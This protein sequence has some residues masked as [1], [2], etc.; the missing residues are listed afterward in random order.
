MFF[1]LCAGYC[2]CRID[3]D[4]L[5]LWVYDSACRFVTIVYCIWQ[6]YLTCASFSLWSFWCLLHRLG[7]FSWSLCSFWNFSCW[8]FGHSYWC[9]WLFL[10]IQVWLGICNF[11]DRCSLVSFYAWRVCHRTKVELT[12][13]DRSYTNTKFSDWKLLAFL[14]F[15]IFSSFCGLYFQIKFHKVIQSVYIIPHYLLYVFIANCQA[16]TCILFE[17]LWRLKYI[18]SNIYV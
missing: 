12:Y 9:F 14:P 18:S 8:S 7:R 10:I 6:S 1:D 17:Y 16:F 15:H 5:S 4:S 3:C 13:H 11:C 2:I